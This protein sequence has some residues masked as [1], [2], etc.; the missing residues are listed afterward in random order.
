V[1]WWQV[2]WPDCCFR[3]PTG[4][5]SEGDIGDPAASGMLNKLA[6][7]DG[8]ASRDGA[9]WELRLPSQGGAVQNTIPQASATIDAWRTEWAHSRMLVNGTLVLAGVVS[10][11]A[12]FPPERGTAPSADCRSG[13]LATAGS[14]LAITL[15]C[16]SPESFAALTA[17]IERLHFLGSFAS[18]N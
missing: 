10:S 11:L 6:A 7:L 3:S 16:C 2:L 8:S 18:L 5:L 14:V 13:N 1:A 15:G 12:Y 4:P 9:S 17:L